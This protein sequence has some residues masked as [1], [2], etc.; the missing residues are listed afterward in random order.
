MPFALAPGLYGGTVPGPCPFTQLTPQFSSRPLLLMRL[1]VPL[2]FCCSPAA[3]WPFSVIASRLLLTKGANAGTPPLATEIDM[4][5]PVGRAGLQFSGELLAGMN[6]LTTNIEPSTPGCISSVR[7][8][9]EAAST[10]RTGCCWRCS[11]KCPPS[12]LHCC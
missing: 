1:A 8:S 7:R 9:L 3:T 12:R 11:W 2:A 4:V 6:V 5:Q 10:S